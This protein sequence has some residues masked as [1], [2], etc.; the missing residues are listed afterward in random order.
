MAS[1][2]VNIR[3]R[4]ELKSKSESWEWLRQHLEPAMRADESSYIT[5][6]A[7]DVIDRNK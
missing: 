4:R 1:E 2:N 6:S 7:Q 5:V 3:I